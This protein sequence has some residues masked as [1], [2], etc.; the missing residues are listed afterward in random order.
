M[1]I[2][3]IVYWILAYMAMNKV[4]YSKKVYLVRDSFG[5]YLQKFILS[6]LLGWL[7]I[8]IA[9]LQLISGRNSK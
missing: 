9:F 4:W 2:L 3:V 7:L 5:F 1:T 6:A 8:P